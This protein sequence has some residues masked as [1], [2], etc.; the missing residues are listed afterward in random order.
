MR[1]TVQ[2]N[3]NMYETFKIAM[4]SSKAACKSQHSWAPSFR[5]FSNIFLAQHK[6]VTIF[7][8]YCTVL[9]IVYERLFLP[10]IQID[11]KLF[12]FSRLK[13]KTKIKNTMIRDMLFADEAVVAAQNPSHLQ[14]FYG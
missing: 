3:G 14:S 5:C 13:A 8:L 2:Y 12:N 4:V 6:K 9:L 10:A 11:G 7:P 1:S